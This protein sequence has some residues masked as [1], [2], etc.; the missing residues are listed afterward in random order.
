[1]PLDVKLSCV[2]SRERLEAAWLSTR[3][4]VP[5]AHHVGRS[6]P[7]YGGNPP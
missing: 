3:P 4:D 6:E 7:V 1:M 2:A 5:D